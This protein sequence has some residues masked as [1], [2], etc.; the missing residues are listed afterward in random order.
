MNQQLEN[1]VAVL[2]IVRQFFEQDVYITVLDTN[3]VVQG[4]TVPDGIRPKLN[5]GERFDDPSG[6]MFEVL[7][8]GRKKHNRLPKEVM[9]EVF[10]GE[11]VPVK[12]GGEIVGCVSC[13]YSVDKR[14]QMTEM[15]T[16]FQESVNSIDHSIQT[17]VEGI[18]TLFQMLTDMDR[19]TTGIEA[20]VKNAV[21]VV[22]KISRNAS[23]SNILALNASIEAAR[24]GDAGRGFAVVAKDMGTLANDSGSSATDIKNTLNTIT[25]HLVSIISSIKDANDIAK[26]HME[27]INSIQKIL[28]E[29]ITLAGKMKED[30]KKDRNE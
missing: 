6:A 16:K 28:Q 18:E 26:E 4:F 14:E 2:P 20:D 30:A 1:L 24:S 25:N 23:R 21:E 13:T 15:T 17:V 3:G 9:G 22:N 5:V 7:R 19:M 12:D 8:T 27:S 10:E 11:L 29:T